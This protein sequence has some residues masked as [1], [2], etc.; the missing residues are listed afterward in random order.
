[1]ELISVVLPVFNGEE[2]IKETVNSV[3]NQTFRNWELI[4]INDGS[5]DATLEIVS[6]IKDERIKVFSYPNKGQPASR[7]RGIA[8]A[9]GEYI[10]F[11]DADDL[12]TADKLEAQYQALRDNPQAA[13][14]YSWTDW[15]DE[16][17]QLLS[18]G[19]YISENGD[20]F[21]QLLLQ[22]FIANGSNPLIR[23]QAL[24]NVGNFDES[25]SNAHDW[26]M[27]LRLAAHYPFVVVPS[28][29]ILYRK[30]T[31][32]MSANV[33]GM[34]A[35][36]LRVIEKALAQAPESIQQLKRSILANRYKYLTYKAV[37][38]PL[39][40]K[41]G[42]AA[43]KFLVTSIQYDPVMLRRFKLISILLFKIAV[44]VGLPDQVVQRRIAKLK[45]L[46]KK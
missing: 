41:R 12:W 32:S 19:S 24:L 37:E 16:S 46:N 5:Q 44:A 18:C 14:A 27:W 21:A 36:S 8:R 2:T 35:S 39:E 33:W 11:I 4:V 38:W 3:L 29:Q 22:D 30:S 13:V 1:M 6:S 26:D 34:E 17:G 10:S 7:N 31:S 23:R 15:I 25:L 43:M 9:K 20:V 28:A 45:L 40:R 42:L